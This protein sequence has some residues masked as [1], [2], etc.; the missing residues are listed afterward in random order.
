MPSL[1]PRQPRLRLDPEAYK[2]LCSQVLGRDNWRC[3]NCGAS[4]N[5]QVH[6]IQWRSKLGHDILE[7]LITLCS[8]CHE[9]LHRGPA[10]SAIARI[11]SRIP[12]LPKGDSPLWQNLWALEFHKR[13]RHKPKVVERDDEPA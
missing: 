4:E 2:A 3:Q 7:N 5:L 10:N 11:K 6:H 1:R 12:L 13:E 9:A 8:N